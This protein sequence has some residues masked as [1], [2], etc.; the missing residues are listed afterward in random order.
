MNEELVNTFN[1]QTFTQVNAFLKIKYYNPP[2]LIVQQ[3]PVKEKVN[4]FE[5]NTMRKGYIVDV[6][7][8]VDIQEIAKVGVKVFEIYEGVIY[9]NNFK[10]SPFKK[11]IGKL[12]ASSQKNK[13]ENN[14]VRQVL[15]K[16]ILNG[17]FGE[18]IQKKTW[19]KNLCVS[20]NAG[21]F[22]NTMNELKIIVEIHMVII[23][24]KL[25][26]IKK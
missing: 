14:D 20:Q 13:D 22:Q 10:V 9:R 5:N 26:M 8:S 12:F 23:L 25:L 19:K 24:L 6:L 2:Y 21:C 18:Q 3:L 15:V 17:L 11:V 1:N 16:A 4:K 7:T